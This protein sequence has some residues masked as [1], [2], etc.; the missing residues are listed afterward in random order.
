MIKKKKKKGNRNFVISSRTSDRFESNCWLQD[1]LVKVIKNGPVS[2]IELNRHVEIVDGSIRS[3]MVP[4]V[5]SF[6]LSLSC[7]FLFLLPLFFFSSPSEKE[8]LYSPP[9]IISKPRSKK[10][11]FTPTR[12]MKRAT[13][14]ERKIY[15]RQ[16]LKSRP[17]S[18]PTLRNLIS[19]KATR[20]KF[21]ASNYFARSSSFRDSS[22][23]EGYSQEKKTVARCARF[24]LTSP[25]ASSL[26]WW[27]SSVNIVYKTRATI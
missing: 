14:L 12:P 17:V 5:F 18:P 4:S 7:F 8:F 10:R 16:G 20:P 27:M 11:T 23:I 9:F 13:V 25:L 2:E 15:A 22:L 19:R 6:C 26:L 24:P 1:N 3:F 21:I